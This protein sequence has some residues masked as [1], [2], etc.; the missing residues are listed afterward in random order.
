[1]ADSNHRRQSRP[2]ASGQAREES[3]R[4]I[5]ALTGALLISVAAFGSTAFQPTTT[6]AKE[7][8]NN[9]NLSS[10]VGTTNGDVKPGNISK[11]DIHTLLYSG[12]TTK[13][14]A[15]YMP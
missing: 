15:H 13:V 11:V 12:T 4:K 3:A 8:A 7:T 10:F 14:F 9:T 1:M 2:A 6:L 5:L